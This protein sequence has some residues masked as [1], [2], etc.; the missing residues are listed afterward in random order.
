MR[1][2]RSIPLA[3]AAAALA[4]TGGCHKKD[5]NADLKAALQQSN[6]RAQLVTAATTSSRLFSRTLLVS[7]EVRPVDQ[8]RWSGHVELVA[9][10]ARKVPA[11]RAPSPEPRASPKDVRAFRV[12][13][14]Q[15]FGAEEAAR[16]A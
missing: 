2:S 6:A 16:A 15:V 8:F 9:G 4:A 3:L 1:V 13:R 12:F 11:R 10:F 14:G 5:A 7:G